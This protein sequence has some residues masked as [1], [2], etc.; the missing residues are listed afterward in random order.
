MSKKCHFVLLNSDKVERP[1][2]PWQENSIQVIVCEGRKNIGTFFFPWV[3]EESRGHLQCL[4]SGTLSSLSK[5]EFPMKSGNQGFPWQA[6]VE[7]LSQRWDSRF[8]DSS[9]SWDAVGRL[10]MS[11]SVPLLGPQPLP[12]SLILSCHLI[13]PSR[14][15]DC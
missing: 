3:A 15:L 14:I 13:I 5:P 11:S 2:C 9:T 10:C 7:N 4:D 6:W 12:K 1:Y 8:L